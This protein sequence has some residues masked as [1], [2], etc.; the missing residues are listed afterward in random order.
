VNELTPDD[1]EFVMT[2]FLNGSSDYINS[3][4]SRLFTLFSMVK[5]VAQLDVVAGN[6]QLENFKKNYANNP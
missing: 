2:L 3:V 4:Y 5:Q 1:I 6:T